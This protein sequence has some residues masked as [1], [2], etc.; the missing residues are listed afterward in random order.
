MSATLQSISTRPALTDDDTFLFDVY[1]SSRGD[2]LA[3]VGWAPQQIQ[4]FLA[5]QYA[6]QQRFHKIDYPQADNLIIL[7]GSER[8][9]RIVVKRDEQEIRLVD[10]ALFPPYRNRGIGT[11][12][13]REFVAEAERSARPL[14]A[15][16]LRSNRAVGL[17]ERMG[18]MITGETGSHYQMEWRAGV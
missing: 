14:R 4:E 15:Q 6:A 9:G 13:I 1:V 12:L 8:A 17:L 3:K 5:T 7:L 18:L 16:V 10:I 2:D 11:H